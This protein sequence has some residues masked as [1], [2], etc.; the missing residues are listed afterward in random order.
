MSSKSTPNRPNAQL[1]ALP[2]LESVKDARLRDFPEVDGG[3]PDFVAKGAFTIEDDTVIDRALRDNQPLR[4]AI[5]TSDGLKKA[6]VEAVVHALIAAKVAVFRVSP[7]LMG[8]VSSSRPIPAIA[9]LVSMPDTR[10]STLQPGPGALYLIAERLANPDNLGMVIRTADAAG[11]DAVIVC[12]DKASPFHKNCVRAARGAVGRLSIIVTEDTVGLLRG[13][14]SQGVS[15]LGSSARADFS[16]Y[17]ASV[18]TP[19]AIL[20]GNETEGVTPEAM[21]ECSA[22]V[23]IPMRPGQSS[24]NVGVAAGVLL[25]ECLRRMDGGDDR[26]PTTDDRR[27]VMPRISALTARV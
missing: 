26:R 25:F 17:D 15:V 12:G 4:H 7:G 23:T 24:L 21:A 18:A 6:P 9:A 19:L 13:L 8:M 14:R 5:V 3:R 2:R 10:A 16:V 11:V 27:P 20:V 1:D 22:R